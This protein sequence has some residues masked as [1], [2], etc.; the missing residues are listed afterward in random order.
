VFK[1]EA[2]KLSGD[3]EFLAQGTIYLDVAESKTG[4]KAHH[5]VGGLPAE[6][7]FKL[8]E[9]LAELVKDEARVLGKKLGLPD[10]LVNRQPFPG[11]GLAIRVMG[12]VTERKLEILRAADAI[13][14]GEI[15][16]A[17]DISC[18]P[19]QYLAVLTDTCSSGV[20]DGKKT[21]DPV[22]AVRAVNTSDFAECEYARLPH[23]LLSRI[24][25][26]ITSELNISRVVYDVTSKP[27]ATLEWE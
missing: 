24:A 23:S 10:S 9:P 6:L 4:V 27:P 19:S 5:N 18:R 11:P 20:K 8:I 14:R 2:A 17:P 13:V 15:E 16:N 3:I 12:E 26:R 21:Y 22:I 7:G 1:E 25:S